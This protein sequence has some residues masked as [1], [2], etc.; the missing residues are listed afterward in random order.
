M[1]TIMSTAGTMLG[2]VATTATALT[3]TVSLLGKG[4]SALSVKMETLHKGIRTDA[5]LQ[6]KTLIVESVHKVVDAHLDILEAFHRKNGGSE[7]FDRPG[8]AQA[9]VLE[10]T[11]HATAPSHEA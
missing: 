7:P 11:R 2:T 3:D 4:I 10:Y 1:A 8:L 9:M 6:D 5:R